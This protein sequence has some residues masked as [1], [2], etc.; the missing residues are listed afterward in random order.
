[1]N[2]DYILGWKSIQKE[3]NLVSFWALRHLELE[4]LLIKKAFIEVYLIYKKQYIYFI[5]FD[6][7]G[8]IHTPRETIIIIKVINISSTSTF[9]CAPFLWQELLKFVKRVDLILRVTLISKLLSLNH[10]GITFLK[11]TCDPW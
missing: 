10:W 9:L 1:M 2:T 6:E 8:P 4:R 3:L 11:E 5:Q 7:F